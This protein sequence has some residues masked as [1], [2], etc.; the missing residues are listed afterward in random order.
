[1]RRLSENHTQRGRRWLALVLAS[2]MLLSSASC[3]AE[4]ESETETEEE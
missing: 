2:C 4:P 1:M 3:A